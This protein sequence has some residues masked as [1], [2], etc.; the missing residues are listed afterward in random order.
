MLEIIITA[1]TRNPG[2]LRL[3]LQAVETVQPVERT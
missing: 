2:E 1:L 3:T